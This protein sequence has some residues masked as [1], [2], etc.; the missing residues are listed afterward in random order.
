MKFIHLLLCS[1]FTFFVLYGPQPI[2]PLLARDH[3]LSEAEAGLLMTVTMLPLAIAPL[4][5][6]YIFLNADH[7]YTINPL[8]FKP[9]HIFKL[10][11]NLNE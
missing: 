2:L 5:Y 6:G 11:I 3:S 8:F 10:N 1:V 4:A 9:K 7:N